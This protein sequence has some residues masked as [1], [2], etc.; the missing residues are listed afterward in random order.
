MNSI[1]HKSVQ[2]ASHI[3]SGKPCQ[4]YSLSYEEQGITIA[5]VC[6]GHG[7]KTYFRSDTGA[8][9]AAEITLD[10]LKGFAHSM[11]SDIYAS[12]KFSITAR[13]QRN[14]FIDSDGNRV[15]FEDLNEGQQKYA[16]QA[17]AYIEAEGKYQEQRS[18]IEALLSQIYAEW[19]EQINKDT[20]KNP[21]DKKE[22]QILDKLGVEKAYG[23]TLLA[24]LKTTDYW[25]SFHIGDGKIMTCDSSL[26][27]EMP[28]PEDCACFLNYTTS[29]CDSNPICEF[30]Y[31]FNGIDNPPIA[32][33][34]CSDGVDGSLRTQENLQDFYEQIIGLV[35]DGDNVTDELTNYLPTLSES[36]NKDDISISGYVDLSNID[37][38]SLRKR[39]DISKKK[40]DIK[41]DYRAR[42]SEIESINDRIESLNIKYERQKDLRFEKQTEL[43]DMRQGIELKEKELK[44]IEET[45]SSIKNESEELKN[46][47]DIK[48]KDFEDW[49]FTIKNEMAESEAELKNDEIKEEDN[50]SIDLTNW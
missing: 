8:R 45:V 25:L 27:W 12:K 34:L 40:R 9:L 38:E 15:R 46:K 30:R 1:F 49:K 48:R 32:A 23:C 13:P 6:D 39:I 42:K 26:N 18:C 35:L 17:Q 19:I 11:P 28:V 2:G 21:F 41:S 47:L 50:P 20:R 4:D 14:P 10:I 37:C 7:G 24:F 43:D 36:G 22:R 31:A 44:A 3:A 16:L 33:F 5:V 29:L